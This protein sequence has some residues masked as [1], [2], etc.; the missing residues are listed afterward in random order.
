MRVLVVEDD[1]PVA[2]FIRRGLEA[3]QY[4]V[5]VAQDGEEAERKVMECDYDL[6]VLDLNLPRTDGFEV[7]RSLRAR[8]ASTPVLILTVRTQIEDR[9]K[10]LDLGADDYLPKPFAFVEL[11]ARVRA[12]LRRSDRSPEVTLRVA[13]LA[14]NRV[15]RTVTRGG[16]EID[17]TRREFALLEYLLRH[18]GRCVT[19]AMVV[20]DVWHYTS[21]T[22]TNVV[23]V[24]INYLR[25]KVDRGFQPKLIHTIR[26]VGYQLGEMPEEKEAA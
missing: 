22:L 18:Q 3:E 17:L 4:A 7:L 2:D 8:N 5:D 26:G 9:V 23:D 10:G 14:L 6:L 19:R 20:Q 13:D 12:L 21:D 16:R 1:K 15:T 24:Y 25:A 11:A